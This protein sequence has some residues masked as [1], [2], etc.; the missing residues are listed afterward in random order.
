MHYIDLVNWL[1]DKFGFYGFVRIK[2]F[3]TFFSGLIVG[4]LL[5]MYHSASVMKNVRPNEKLEKVSIL[6]VDGTIFTSPPKSLFE[7]IEKRFFIFLYKTRLF[8]KSIE[9]HNKKR[10][11]AL[12]ISYLA[13]IGVVALIGI[14]L[15]VSLSFLDGRLIDDKQEDAFKHQLDIETHQQQKED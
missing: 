10:M 7:S 6:V 8:R 13:V 11:R 2:G 5:M 1:V 4:G 9:F 3:I 12:F 15:S 14:Y